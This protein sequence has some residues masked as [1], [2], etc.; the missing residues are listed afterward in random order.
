M[1]T[2]G[3]ILFTPE[4]TTGSNLTQLT[5]WKPVGW[6]KC[7]QCPC[8][9]KWKEYTGILG[10][11]RMIITPEIAAGFH[12]PVIRPRVATYAEMMRNGTWESS[13]PLMIWNTGEVRNGYIRLAAVAKAGVPVEFDV[14][15]IVNCSEVPLERPTREQVQKLLER[16]WRA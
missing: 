9:S 5:P 10:E 6:V 3:G 13:A 11:Y 1:H 12:G 8:V 4:G 14:R 7:P 2:L 15:L 16:G